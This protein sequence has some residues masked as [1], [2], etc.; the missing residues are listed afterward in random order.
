MAVVRRGSHVAPAAGRFRQ[1]LTLGE[2]DDSEPERAV[3][4]SLP[5]L[6][7]EVSHSVY[8]TR[9]ALAGTASAPFVCRQSLPAGRADFALVG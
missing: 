5:S 1:D 6:G 7:L 3:A 8:V 4:P 9:A 2:G